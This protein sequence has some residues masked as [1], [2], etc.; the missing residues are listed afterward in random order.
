MIGLILAL[1]LASIILLMIN[2]YTGASNHQLEDINQTLSNQA[3]KREQELE[4]IRGE[5]KEAKEELE[6][7]VAKRLP[8]LTRLEFDKVFPVEQGL[9]KNIAF[10]T[11]GKSDKQEYE[12]KLVFENNAPI[13]AKTVVT[14][15]FFSEFGVQVGS[16]KKYESK[17]L[18]PEERS[19]LSSTLE[20]FMDEKPYYFHVNSV[21]V[22]N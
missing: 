19:S 18:E 10:T 20:L 1:A 6:A 21:R 5:L 22:E 7:L 8:K 9:V 4:L 15:Y 12:Y 17:E 16:T 14:I 13:P 11:I 3:F 2:I